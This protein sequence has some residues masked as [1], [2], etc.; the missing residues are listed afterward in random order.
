MYLG[1]EDKKQLQCV[2]CLYLTLYKQMCLAKPDDIPGPCN[3]FNH[4]KQ[5]P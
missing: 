2:R 5:S 1:V 4:L 3:I